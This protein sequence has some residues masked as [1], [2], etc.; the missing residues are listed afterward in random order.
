MVGRL[1][2]APVQTRRPRTSADEMGR[3][4]DLTIA[5]LPASVKGCIPPTWSCGEGHQQPTFWLSNA[6]I[7]TKG[8]RVA[9]GV[10]RLDGARRREMPGQLG[11]IAATKGLSSLHHPLGESLRS[12][13]CLL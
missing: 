12:I 3:G 13:R 10:G 8:A 5:A 9:Q 7:Q 6:A 4:C 1:A 2:S 11:R